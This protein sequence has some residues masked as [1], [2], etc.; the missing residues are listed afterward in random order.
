M[1]DLALLRLQMEWGADEALEA[2]PVDRL[3]MPAAVSMLAG[4]GAP[5]HAG[6]EAQQMPPRIS[7]TAVPP[8]LTRPE[9]MASGPMAPR[10][11]PAIVA[12]TDAERAARLVEPA[13]SL[14]A[15]RDAIAG[16]DFC[17]L[18][19][20]AS[21]LV[22]AEGDHSAGVLV[23]GD[24]PGMEEDRGGH[25]LAGPE[26]ALFDRMLASIGLTRQ[27]VLCAPLIPWRPPGGR[28]P[29]PGELAICLPFL[30]RLIVLAEPRR[31]V[32]LGGEAVRALLPGRGR[33]RR[34]SPEW[35]SARIPGR[36]D[37]LP[38]LVLPGLADI[39]KE[40]LRRRDAWAAL[41]RLRHGLNEDITKM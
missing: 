12:V 38:A 28:A 29:Y 1:D 35:E 8:G 2:D 4:P 9:P 24:P 39:R 3:R 5:P 14:E 25:P 32:L 36:T 26:G 21:N 31:L 16:C 6:P 22:F 17:A 19:D 40:P 27:A 23:I 37:P 20:T 13:A 15:L 33:R 41:R 18:R 30:H 34:T 11:T 7:L 10:P